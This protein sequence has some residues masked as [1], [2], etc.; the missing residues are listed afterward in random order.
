MLIPD[1][2]VPAGE[3][4]VAPECDVF[5]RP[6]ELVELLLAAQPYCLDAE[7]RLTEACIEKEL[8]WICSIR[9]GSASIEQCVRG[10]RLAYH[11]GHLFKNNGESSSQRGK[12]INALVG[13][14]TS[15]TPTTTLQRILITC[16][17]PLLV[18]GL[19]VGTSQLESNRQSIVDELA[20]ICSEDFDGEGMLASANL[21]ELAEVL[22]SMARMIQFVG[23]LTPGTSLPQCILDQF[24]WG[25]RQ[26]LV[27][28]MSDGRPIG[29]KFSRLNDR[30]VTFL[31]QLC[32]DPS[33][34]RLAHHLGFLSDSASGF[35]TELAVK[36]KLPKASFHSEWAQVAILRSGWG[37]KRRELAVC[38]SGTQV[39]IGL[40]SCGNRILEGRIEFTLEVAGVRLEP[41][42][43]WVETCWQSDSDADFLEMELEVNDC[44]RI[45]R[46]FCVSRRSGAVLIADVVLGTANSDVRHTLKMGTASGATFTAGNDGRE[47]FVDTGNLHGL[48]LPIGLSE[49]PSDRSGSVR[50]DLTGANE[51]ELI[52][53]GDQLSA[54]YCP[55]FFALTPKAAEKQY[56]WR[57]LVVAAKLTQEAQDQ[58]SASRIQVGGRQWLLYRSLT[59]QA[60]RT[61]MGQN[62]AS[63]F[64]FGEFLLDGKLKPY[65]EIE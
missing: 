46:Q 42:G 3:T 1:E 29:G 33:D 56:T 39:E 5:S 40:H 48:V 4:A 38:V 47:L 24:R 20:A 62:Y 52:T 10:L 35:I 57:Q 63:E 14:A 17:I 64:V 13:I 11:A 43:S 22:A 9:T 49:W 16:E 45:Q 54:L 51:L 59:E 15:V 60:N 21:C 61:F 7:L 25:V 27:I 34:V 19:Q 18:F 28:C 53:R 41:T 30:F 37:R 58:A 44:W 65:V 36:A 55:L 32:G 50:G 26:L 12:L 23:M 31:L 8:T 6:D 2:A